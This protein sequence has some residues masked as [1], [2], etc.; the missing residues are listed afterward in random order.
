MMIASTSKAPRRLLLSLIT[1]ALFFTP[2]VVLA[3]PA[4]TF[5]QGKVTA[6]RA[7]L[8]QPAQTPAARRSLDQ[9]LLS[10]VQPVIDF[11]GMSERSLGRH[12]AGLNVGQRAEFIALFQEL[13]FRSYLNKIRRANEAYEL[14]YEDEEPRAPGVFVLATSNSSTFEV[15]LGFHLVQRAGS[16]IAWDLVID[17]V[18]LT[19]NYR[20]QFNR[21]IIQESFEALLRR[22]R[23]KIASLRR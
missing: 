3:G 6:V 11:P 17:E 16:W 14:E 7:L 22:M 18:S 21:I 20:E 2:A 9:Q 8:A 23:S 5:L 4:T 13:V 15:E 10:A 19:E 12:W 1:G